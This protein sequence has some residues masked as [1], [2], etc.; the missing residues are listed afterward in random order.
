MDSRTCTSFNVSRVALAVASEAATATAVVFVFVEGDR[1]TTFDDWGLR[2][3]ACWGSMRRSN[4]CLWCF[5]PWVVWIRPVLNM[6]V[7]Q[8]QQILQ[9]P[10]SKTSQW[11]R[12]VAARS[13]ATLRG[14]Q[15]QQR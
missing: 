14:P 11:A 2:P 5:L 7:L 15:Q 13:F 10:K 6:E 9:R 3:D 12:P 4:C 1:G 8:I